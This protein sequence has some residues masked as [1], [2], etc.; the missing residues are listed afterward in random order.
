VESAWG[1]TAAAVGILL[2]VAFS[3]IGYTPAAFRLARWCLAIS[4][5]L[6]GG[7]DIAWQIMTDYP[8]W[9]RIVVGVSVG[10][11]V[12]V[13]LPEG[14][15]WI[16]TRQQQAQGL[17]RIEPTNEVSGKP[18]FHIVMYDMAIVPWRD[19]PSYAAVCLIAGIANTGSA[20]VARAFKLSIPRK[21]GGIFE[22][23]LSSVGSSPWRIQVDESKF[24]VTLRQEDSLPDKT[25]RSVIPHGGEVTGYILVRFPGVP[26]GKIGALGNGVTLQIE[27]IKGQKYN[28]NLRPSLAV[29]ITPYYPGTRLNDSAGI[30]AIQHTPVV[31]VQL[32]PAVDE[33]HATSTAATGALIIFANNTGSTITNLSKLMLLPAIKSARVPE[34][35]RSRV[36]IVSGN[37]KGSTFIHLELPELLTNEHHYVEVTFLRPSK[38]TSADAWGR[39]YGYTGDNVMV[40]RLFVGP[41]EAVKPS[42]QH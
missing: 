17:T 42:E 16:T 8:I 15:R 31:S 39:K 18:E 36:T 6:L 30:Q 37:K 3:A 23:I 22:G 32:M 20:S 19:D 21:D 13:G 34:A 1:I 5:L 35:H 7:T 40:Y 14:F 27:D 41:P 25:I 38:V 4:A 10:G 33:A 12:F 11:I 26:S 9:W 28:R 29:G 24:D 2:T